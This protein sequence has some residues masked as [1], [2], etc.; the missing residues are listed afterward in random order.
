MKRFYFKIF[1]SFSNLTLLIGLSILANA[2]PGLVKDI[3][4]EDRQGS[5]PQNFIEYK[6]KVYF[7]AVRE[8]LEGQT[9]Y[10]TDGTEAGTQ[11]VL[12]PNTNLPVYAA[13]PMAVCNDLLFFLG[14]PFSEAT[15]LEPVGSELCAFD[16]ANIRVV[17]DINP[18]I[19]GSFA[20]NFVAYGNVLLF[21]ASNVLAQS[22]ITLNNELWRS[23][24][25]EAG[26]ILVKDIN[27]GNN[28]GGP[29]FLK[30]VNNKVVLFAEDGVHG[31]E[32]W[33]TDGT[34]AGTSLLKDITEGSTS[35]VQSNPGFEISTVMNDMLYFTAGLGIAN[36]G[37]ELYRT[38]GTPEGTILLKNLRTG[39]GSSPR[40][41][42]TIGNRIFFSA[43]V[44]EAGGIRVFVTDGTA[45]GTTVVPNT[46]P[47]TGQTGYI[48][49][50]SAF[51]N[52]VYFPRSTAAQG[53]EYWYTN[54]P[55]TD[56]AQLLKDINPGNGSGVANGGG[57]LYTLPTEAVMFARDNNINSEL[58]RTDGTSAE[59]LATGEVR[60]GNNNG[61]IPS[62]PQA[63]VYS[64]KLIFTAQP[65]VEIGMELFLYSTPEV[66]LPLHRIVFNAFLQNKQVH[67]PWEINQTDN[68]TLHIK[69]EKASNGN[70]FVQVADTTLFYPDARVKGLLIDKNPSVGNNSYRLKITESDGNVQYTVVR[71]VQVNQLNLVKIVAAPNPANSSIT[72]TLQGIANNRSNAL[73]TITDATGRVVKS[74]RVQSIFKI[75]ISTWPEGIYYVTIPE[76]DMAP[77]KFMKLK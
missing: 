2:Q 67:C 26:T 18:G 9:L 34:E 19:T 52:R 61:A 28:S 13:L 55:G 39:L 73:A 8:R 41:Y 29:E 40:N 77:F 15:T 75:D 62:Q 22:G 11:Q 72:F 71:T 4:T 46:L 42:T 64:N 65:S 56:N 35:S 27:P 45:D 20:G 49:K 38:D 16:G 5:N 68:S 74:I 44:P 53:E 57:L 12:Q 48:D 3:N 66:D 6:G 14:T 21:S 17:K 69:L 7:Q 58:W 43:N 10:V 36:Q 1:Q 59:T 23:D 30:V 76:S 32:P 50:F 31:R 47:F 25:T 24:G 54:M 37:A 70:G 33:I 63:I 51:N 60:P